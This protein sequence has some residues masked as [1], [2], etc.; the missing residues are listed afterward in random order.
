MSQD[1]ELDII[2]DC[3]DNDIKHNLLTLLEKKMTSL[4]I[5]ARYHEILANT[6]SWRAKI[7]NY[8][9]ILVTGLGFVMSTVLGENDGTANVPL[10]IIS[11]IA[12][13]IKG[14]EEYC[15]YDEKATLHK[16]NYSEALDMADDI[17]YIILKN[18]HSRDS[19]QHALDIYEERIKSFRKNEEPIPVEIKHKYDV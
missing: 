14:S 13:I 11:G 8:S 2:I 5:S 4:Q 15:D 17:E 9:S 10:A 3:N 18:N 12:I 6:Y 19:L 7:V 1:A 16:Q